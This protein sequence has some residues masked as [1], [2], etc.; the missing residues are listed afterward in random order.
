MKMDLNLFTVFET[1]YREGNI[2]KAASALNLS[3]PAVSHALA[4]LRVHFDDKLF[5]RKGNHM[6]PTALAKGVI[7]DVRESLR[8]L[9]LSLVQS[10][11]FHPETS[12]K[13]CT[14]SM[15][16]ALEATYLPLFMERLVHQAPH[17][18]L[19]SNR[20]RRS[21]LETKL[22]SGDIDIAIDILLPV[23]DAVKH[24][25]VKQD[26]LVVVGR[27]DHPLLQQAISLDDYLA[28]SH[29]LVS[30]RT[31]GPSIEDFELGRLGLQRKIGLRCQHLF[32]AC[33]VI[34]TNDMLLT[35]P[36]NAALMYSELLN[37]SIA[38]IPVEL[39]SIDVHVYWHVN[40]DKEPANIWIREQMIEAAKSYYSNLAH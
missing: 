24:K 33:R 25:R 15:H 37:L 23:D 6:R 30:A 7:A 31:S 27:K 13:I 40:V 9:Q 28:Q 8:Q 12:R 11:Q 18:N 3:Q 16:S 2:S 22:A 32:S 1:I 20:V 17:I 19:T 5:I 14:V 36:E 35:L 21:E 39:P 26:K 34:S 10:R 29:V 4:K 38:P